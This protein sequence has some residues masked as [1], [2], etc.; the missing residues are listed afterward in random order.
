[1]GEKSFLQF[2][3]S[4][5]ETRNEKL[6]LSCEKIKDTKKIKSKNIKNEG[7]VICIASFILLK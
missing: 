7:F 6:S 2:F 5:S 3:F 1:L 4:S